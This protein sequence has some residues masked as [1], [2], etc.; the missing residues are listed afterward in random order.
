MLYIYIK[1]DF[2]EVKVCKKTSLFALWDIVSYSEYCQHS[3]INHT[4]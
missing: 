2:Y 4:T 3:V 1:Q